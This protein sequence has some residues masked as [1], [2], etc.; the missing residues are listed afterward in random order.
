M[1]S[2]EQI[3]A[4][5]SLLLDIYGYQIEIRG[6]SQTILDGLRDDFA[7]FETSE[8]TPSH[9]IPGV[10]PFIELIET[11]PP[12]YEL[13]P[14]SAT[15][16]TPRNVSYRSGDLTLIDYSGRA[17]GIHN[18]LTGGFRVFS[19]NPD[20]LYEAAYLFLLSQCGEALDRRRMHRVHALGVSIGGSAALVLLPMGGG[21]STLG[22]HL[23]RYPELSLL[24]D[25]SPLIDSR[26][27]V[28]AFPLRIGLLPGSEGNIPADQ[29]RRIERMEFGP[30]LLVNYS[31]FAERVASRA[32]PCLIL[33][34]RRSL[35]ATCSVH[36]AGKTAALRSLITNC[37]IG[38][39]LF[40]GME[41]VFNRGPL[42]VFRKASIAFS[43]LR[44]SVRLLSRSQAYYIDLGRNSEENARAVCQLLQSRAASKR[45]SYHIAKDAP[46]TI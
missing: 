34:G 10:R 14:A 11:D 39:G 30:K 4:V 25:D 16:Y 1:S 40:Q 2:T 26:G 5:P 36:P 12:Y 28:H 38:M 35:A 23:L 13:P 6:G 43:R 31:Y 8:T 21:K 29:L 45:G 7:F 27:S 46:G 42:E 24:S 9:G 18:R 19:R 44:A 15:V 20:L 3:A 41:F 32:E 17:L 33:L 37:V 22:S